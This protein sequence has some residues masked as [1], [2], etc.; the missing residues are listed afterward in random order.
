MVNSKKICI[1]KFVWNA[2]NCTMSA[3]CATSLVSCERL[4]SI[5]IH[6]ITI[7]IVDGYVAKWLRGQQLIRT[8]RKREEIQ[9]KKKNKKIVHKT[10]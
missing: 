1:N 8:S 4:V 6:E 7:D 9:K 2:A 3:T 10:N 5:R